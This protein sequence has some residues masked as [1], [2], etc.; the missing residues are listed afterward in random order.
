MNLPDFKLERYLAE[1]EFA[2]PYVLCASDC[3]PISIRDLLA[4]EPGALE[5]LQ[6]L[7]LGYREPAGSPALREEISRLYDDVS[8][9]EIIAFSGASEGIFAFMNVALDRG[10]HVIVQYPAYQSLYEVARSNGCEVTLWRMQEKDTWRLDL[11]L[12]QESIKKTTKAIVINSPHNPTGFLLSREEC[13]EL[14]GIARDHELYLFSDEVYRF[15]EYVPGDRPEAMADCYEKGIS[16]GVMSKAFGL[17]GLRVGWIAVKDA[18]LRE[19]LARFRDYTTICN[20]AP[21]EFLAI[22]GLRH[23]EFLIGRNLEII[24]RNL[25]VLDSFFS[26]H[27]DRFSWSRPR[28]GSTAFPRIEFEADIEEYC[29]KLV[30]AQ[31]VLLLPG[32]M[33][34]YDAR[35][36]RIGF[37]RKDM[38]AALL[39][40]EEYLNAGR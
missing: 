8:P 18:D 12:L 16:L 11:D 39:Q 1:Y 14:V 23:K 30:R 20:S 17:A 3:E 4:P 40:F 22:L 37:G 31:G 21:S 13:R 25:D 27:A 7:S 26:R 33:F 6:A 10:D 34:E 19:K 38:P 36:F 9:E 24:Q 2:A 15:L 35:H 5:D 29:R 32:T 28:A